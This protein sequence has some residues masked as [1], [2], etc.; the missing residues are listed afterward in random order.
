MLG[1]SVKK[2]KLYVTEADYVLEVHV[3]I[4]IYIYISNRGPLNRIKMYIDVQCMY[5]YIW[6]PSF[7][8][9]HAHELHIIYAYMHGSN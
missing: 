8:P 4:Y 3:Y 9:M 2:H 6:L 5:M 1:E 7:S